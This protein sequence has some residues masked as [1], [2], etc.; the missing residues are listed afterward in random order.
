MY[1]VMGVVAASLNVIDVTCVLRGFS[2]CRSMASV[3]GV[4]R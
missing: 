4:G 3:V 1:D 2:G